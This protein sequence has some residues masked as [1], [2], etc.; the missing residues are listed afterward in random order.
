MPQSVAAWDAVA[1]L[2]HAWITGLILTAI[3]RRSV[4]GAAD[5]VFRTFRRQQREKF[6]PGLAKLG[7]R[8]LP[9]AIAC[10]QYH[11]LSNDVGGVRVEYMYESDRKAWVRYVPPR[12]IY[13]GATICAVPSE[14]TRAILRGWHAN[15]GV[16]L[17][18]DR[19]GFVCT[20]MTT[21]GQPGLEGYYHE[22][23]RPLAPEE[24]LRF[25]PNE[26]GPDFDAARAPHLDLA[27]WPPSASRRPPATTR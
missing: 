11:Y 20:K 5:L 26:D 22:H 15:N 17:G 21:D 18:N 27:T 8:G 23:E 13:D 2:Y 6:L 1:A 3:S 4:A 7:L 24:R 9:D 16:L 10:A 25:A 19:L 12:W 14:V